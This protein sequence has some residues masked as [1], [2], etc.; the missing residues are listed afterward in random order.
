VI[1]FGDATRPTMS[2]VIAVLAEKFFLV[3]ETLLSH[4]SDQQPAAVSATAQI[5]VKFPVSPA[6]AMQRESRAQGEGA[7]A[8]PNKLKAA[9]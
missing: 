2:E 9:N 1:E 5:P 3:L 4:A 8:E 7:R 6:L